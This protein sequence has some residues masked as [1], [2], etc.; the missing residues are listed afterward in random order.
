MGEWVCSFRGCCGV[1][2]V[3]LIDIAGGDVWMES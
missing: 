2:G 1:R 3:A